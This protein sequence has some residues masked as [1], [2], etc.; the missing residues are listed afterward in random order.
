MNEF[1]TEI[2]VQMANQNLEIT[3]HFQWQKSRENTYTKL[4]LYRPRACEEMEME[5]TDIQTNK[6]Q[7]MKCTEKLSK[8]KLTGIL[9]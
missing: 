3:F 8:A 5:L 1:W 9:K 7:K 2:P 6:E 4:D